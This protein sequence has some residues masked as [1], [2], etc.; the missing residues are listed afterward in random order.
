MT[1]AGPHQYVTF[2]L[3]GEEYALKIQH[4]REII[5]Y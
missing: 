1:S 4:V 2:N 3:M 5:G